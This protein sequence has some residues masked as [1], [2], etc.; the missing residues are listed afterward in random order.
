M[1]APR[2]SH[3]QLPKEDGGT[4]SSVPSSLPVGPR[5]E[6]FRDEVFEEYRRAHR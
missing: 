1:I 5:E 4:R 3:L 2:R 6:G